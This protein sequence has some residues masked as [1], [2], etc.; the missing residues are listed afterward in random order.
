MEKRP[1]FIGYVL[2]TFGK[3]AIGTC[4]TLTL[5]LTYFYLEPLETGTTIIYTI[6]AI[7]AILHSLRNVGNLTKYKKTL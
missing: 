2:F 4:G 1:H 5:M 7:Y 6:M 3:I